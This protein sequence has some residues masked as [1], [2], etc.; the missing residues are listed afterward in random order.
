MT[1]DNEFWR[2]K[3]VVITGHTGFKGAWLAA[4]LK[5]L[6]ADITGIA[7]APDNEPALFDLL[8]LS[9]QIDHQLIDIRE[10]QATIAAIRQANP[11]VLFHLAAQPLVIESYQ[12][13]IATLSTNVMGTAHVLEAARQCSSLQSIVVITTD[14]VYHSDASGERHSESD[15]LGGHDPYSASKAC[16][17]LL[18]ESYRSS[19]FNHTD[20]TKIATVRA[21][22]VIGGGDFAKNRLVP[23]ICRAWAHG[24][25]VTIRQPK[26]IRP[27]QHVL[28]ALHGYLLLAQQMVCTNDLDQA[29]NIGPAADDM[30][31]V[32]AIVEH[33]QTL[34]EGAKGMKIEPMEYH[35]NPSLLLNSDAI[36]QAVGW[37]PVWD[38][39]CALEH[40]TRWYQL[41]A[42][43]LDIKD[44]T[45]CQIEQFMRDSLFA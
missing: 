17:E 4:W 21:G 39:S 24:Q 31:P 5:Q 44:L 10:Q 2:G 22:N 29:W 14:K 18:V 8:E 20:A 9:A 32:A 34:W 7:L 35:E 37:Q 25:V 33:M 16:C 43:G 28:E 27:W 36:T 38:L 13:P 30:W 6:G 3:R 45:E 40:T 42:D 26:A 23:D 1:L 41:W 11:D 15:H 19:F 12:Q